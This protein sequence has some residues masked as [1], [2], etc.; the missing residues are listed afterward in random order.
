[1]CSAAVLVAAEPY[2][3]VQYLPLLHA[4]T[5]RLYQANYGIRENQNGYSIQNGQFWGGFGP[6]RRV[7]QARQWT[8]NWTHNSCEQKHVFNSWIR[9]DI[10][11]HNSCLQK[12]ATWKGQILGQV[13][14]IRQLL[15]CL[16]GSFQTF[17]GCLRPCCTNSS[18][19]T[20]TSRDGTV[21]ASSTQ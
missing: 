16:S 20:T 2:P 4:C 5:Y 17:H 14:I 7:I 6:G 11:S 21:P 9:R 8:K 19:P 12:K 15:C 1:M 3:T 10:R 13:E 18:C